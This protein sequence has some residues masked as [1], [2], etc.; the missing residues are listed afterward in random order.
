MTFLYVVRCNFSDDASRAEWEEWYS[1]EKQDWLLSRPGFLA[2]QRFAAVDSTDGIGYLALYALDSPAALT[3]PEYSSGWGWGDY[4]PFI[5]DWTRNLYE[6]IGPETFL[7]GDDELLEVVVLG[8]DA[9]TDAAVAA[10][11]DLAWSLS[12]GALDGS[13]SALG[14]AKRSATAHATEPV[15][16]AAGWAA[17]LFRPV[18]PARY[19]DLFAS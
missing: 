11:S 17:G 7:T 3:T 1:T 19:S 5:V 15:L 4:R 10:R 12:D 13:A 9:D 14:V 6:G 16:V 2:G 8:I 18:S